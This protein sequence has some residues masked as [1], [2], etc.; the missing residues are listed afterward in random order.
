MLGTASST[1]IAFLMV[2]LIQGVFAIV[3]GIGAYAVATQRNAVL[4]WVAWSA[5]SAFT[6]IILANQ[7]QE[8]PFIAVVAG[9]IAVMA[10]QRG[11]RLFV[12]EK[13]PQRVHLALLAIALIASWVGGA[14][15]NRPVQAALNYS[16]LSF[17]YCHTAWDLYRHAKDRLQ[18]R[19]PV[20]LALPVLFGG[21]AYG[22]RVVRA[23]VDPQSVLTQM[24]ADSSLNVHGALIFV[25]LVLSLH[26]TLMVLVV[27]RLV[28][29]LRRLSR[30]DGLTGLLN[31]RAMEELLA[32]QV[33]RSR[34][35]EEAFAVMMLDLDH[36][37]R[38]NDQH[39]HPV[40]D[41]ALKHVASLLAEGMPASASLARFG[42]EEFVVLLR[43]ASAA[44][45]SQ[46]AERLRESL[47]SRPIAH[48]GSALALSV[49]IGVAQWRGRTD[50]LAQLFLRADGALF[51]AKV[52]GRNRVVL[53]IDTRAQQPAMA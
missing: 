37:K 4:H 31:R 5:L 46:V 47:A 51:Q 9:V 7:F 27:A 36:F 42:G 48:Q 23:I 15:E 18:F 50:E 53:S 35:S 12:G 14:P 17:L 21:V 41:L 43:G 30:H 52:Q 44:Q 2:A 1:E 45:A 10:L 49:S 32:A 39:G 16:V 29:E 6:W 11:I 20:I 3:W 22:S 28:N 19:L 38:I 34:R 26:A 40:G 8:P 24:A 13:P 33:E 25:V